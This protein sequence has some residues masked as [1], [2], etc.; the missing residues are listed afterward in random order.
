MHLNQLKNDL[1]FLQTSAV[2]N[3]NSWMGDNMEKA[4]ITPITM[5]GIHCRMPGH[6]DHAVFAVSNY[7]AAEYVQKVEKVRSYLFRF[8]EPEVSQ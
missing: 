5:E 3:E 6:S 7:L 2:G 4:T 8:W 1:L